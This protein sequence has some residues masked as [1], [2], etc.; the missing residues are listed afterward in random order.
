[1]SNVVRWLV[2]LVGG[3]PAK[4]L[5]LPLNVAR[6]WLPQHRDNLLNFLASDTGIALMQRMRCV[7]AANAQA[8]AADVMHTAHSAGIT[9]GFYDALQWLE[10]QSRIEFETI[11]GADADQSATSAQ[12]SQGEALLREHYSP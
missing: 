9:T 4:P 12:E 1:M 10:S 7:A 5:P 8:G 2:R 6:A 11:S 3:A